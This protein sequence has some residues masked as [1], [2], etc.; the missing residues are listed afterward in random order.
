MSKR[1]MVA[2]SGGVDSSVA[3]YL[4]KQQGYEV[5]GVTMCL[6]IPAPDEGEAKCCGVEA[7]NDAKKVCAKIGIAHYVLDFAKE[8]KSKVIDDFIS[9]YQL[10]RTPNPCARCNEHLKFAKLYDYAITMGCDYLATG[11]YVKINEIDGESV[12]CRPKDRRKD[13]TYFLY[14]IPKKTLSHLLFPMFNYDKEEIR[15]IASEAE[16]PVANKAESQDI[17]FVTGKSYKQFLSEQGVVPVAGEIVD[18]DGNVLGRHNGIINFTRGQRGGLGIAVGRP[19]YV[20][21]VD[22]ST[23]RVVVGDKEDLFSNVIFT[24]PVNRL[25]ERFPEKVFAKIRYA[26]KEAACSCVFKEDGTAEVLFE[27]MQSAVT[28]GQ[29]IVFYDEDIVLGGAIIEKAFKK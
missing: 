18:L 22:A 29:S 4:L 1:V 21:D 25:V 10:G 27:E 9:E 5:L 11:H 6:G 3:A 13:Q 23:N 7:I 24:S 8:L 28:P 17:C 16:L 15:K 19:L 2:M 26:H 12:L 20:V 14:C